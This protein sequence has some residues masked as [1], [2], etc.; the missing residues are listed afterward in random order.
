MQLFPCFQSRCCHMAIQIW[1]PSAPRPVADSSGCWPP[2]GSIASIS[3]WTT[4]NHVF[5]FFLVVV[6][7]LY[8]TFRE[9]DYVVA[10]LKKQSE[11]G[12]DEKKERMFPLDLWCLPVIMVV[13]MES[14]FNNR[15]PLQASDDECIGPRPLRLHQLTFWGPRKK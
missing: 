4:I 11:K 15:G 10:T 14:A 8:S 3:S 2:P 5:W 7:S 9:R 13:Y 6:S 12:E 1:S